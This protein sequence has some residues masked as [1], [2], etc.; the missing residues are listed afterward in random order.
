MCNDELKKLEA[1]FNNPRKYIF[2]K[3]LQPCEIACFLSHAKCW[4]QLVNSD[5]DWA[6]I[7]EDDI[8][9]SPRFKQFAESIDWIP[10]D[11]RV[12]QLHGSEQMFFVGKRYQV[13]DTELLQIIRPA[14]LGCLAYL[15]HRDAAA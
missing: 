3:A 12:I 1:Q 15:I 5:S 2:K 8:V 6:L 14:P 9:L 4:E 7:M 11:V 10:S 13:R